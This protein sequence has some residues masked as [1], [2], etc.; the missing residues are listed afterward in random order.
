MT[1]TKVL[2]IDDD[3]ITRKTL[4]KTLEKAGFVTV[5]SSNGKHGWETLWENPDIAL[6]VTDMMMPDMDGRELLNVVRGNQC[7]ANLP[8]IIVS[9]IVDETEVQD[10]LK[11]GPSRFCAKPFN[12][13]KLKALT[14]EL[15]QR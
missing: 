3:L 13:D 1:H 7:F 8:V 4:V 12:G 2:V 14:D 11:L 9:G 10:L 5:Q 6:V 15:L